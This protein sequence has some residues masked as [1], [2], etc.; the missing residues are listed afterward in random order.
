MKTVNKSL[1]ERGY[2]VG[3]RGGK[4]WIFQI[5]IN[6][7]VALDVDEYARNMT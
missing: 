6:Y 1:R 2:T 5:G 4:T 7:E 3:K